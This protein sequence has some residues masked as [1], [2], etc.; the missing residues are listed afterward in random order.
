MGLL[1][2]AMVVVKEIGR[3]MYNFSL[4]YKGAGLNIFAQ[5]VPSA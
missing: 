2:Q 1:R 3:R 5:L 4:F